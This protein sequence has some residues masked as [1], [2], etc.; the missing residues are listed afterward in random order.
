[1]KE[2]NANQLENLEGGK[3]WG[4]DCY[5]QTSPGGCSETYFCDYYTFWIKVDSDPKDFRQTGLC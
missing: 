1:M 3:F 5:W 2:L 4:K